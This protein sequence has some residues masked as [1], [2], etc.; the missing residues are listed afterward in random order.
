MPRG[1]RVVDLG[2]QLGGLGQPLVPSISASPPAY[3]WPTART[4]QAPCLRYSSRATTADS[5]SRPVMV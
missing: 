1:H 2:G 3:P 5:A 4:F